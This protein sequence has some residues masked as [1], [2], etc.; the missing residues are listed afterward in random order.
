M[1]E[2][3]SEFISKFQ[4]LEKLLKQITNSSNETRFSDTLKKASDSN[5]YINNN[6]SLIEDLYALRNVFSHRERGKYV[7][8]INLF[9]IKKL[10]GLISALENPRTVI[11]KFKKS[12]F[13]ATTTSFIPSVM[14]TMKEEVYTHVPVWQKKEFI[15]VFSYTSFFEWLADRQQIEDRE[16]TFTK[17]LIGDIN[18]KYL[19]SPCVNYQFVSE[20]TNIYTIPPIFEK[21][22]SQKKRLDCILITPNGTK[23]EKITGIITSWD[24]G[25][26]K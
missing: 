5:V 19:N 1:D 14:G 2:Q 23:G 13:Q 6:Y 15:G 4:K 8:K 7:A 18:R 22:T 21:A 11:S 16:I 9:V 24:L 3:T 10:D 12:I 25:D 26:I 17:K 20:P